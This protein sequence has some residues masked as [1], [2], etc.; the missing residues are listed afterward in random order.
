VEISNHSNHTKY[1][2]FSNSKL[3][4]VSADEI[5][6][7]EPTPQ[8]FQ[9]TLSNGVFYG[10][11]PTPQ[12]MISGAFIIPPKTRWLYN[13]SR[14]NFKENL[15]PNHL[16]IEPEGDVLGSLKKLAKRYL[17]VTPN[18]KIAIENSGGVDSA[19]LIGILNLLGVE[20][21]LIG[22]QSDSYEARTERI[23][24]DH[25]FRELPN[26]ALVVPD[27]FGTAFGGLS[28]VP[29]HAV[30]SASL[31]YFERHTRMAEAAQALGADIVL[32]GVAGDNLFCVG[33]DKQPHYKIPQSLMPWC[34][35]DNWVSDL[36]YAPR[37]MRY[38]AGHSLLSVIKTIVSTRWNQ[39]EDIMKMWA[40]REFAEI[41]PTQLSQFAYKA[42]HDRWLADGI[43]ASRDEICALADRVHKKIR[44]PMLKGSVVKHNL[45]R[46]FEMNHSDMSRFII[47]LSFVV[48]A[49]SRI[50]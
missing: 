24:Q 11:R 3:E 35:A 39:P 19:T 36:I 6:P 13:G 45:D 20:I 31:L 38:V 28:R 49:N 22:L 29:P 30:P 32:N 2:I 17:R 50:P 37:G 44:N 1:A 42:S 7:R 9:N 5:I 46:Y 14:L 15:S 33:L 4:L 43:H 12:K 48:W 18:A 34:L 8:D 25:F 23:I 16:P 41:L 27:S 40:R 21:Y 10:R 26:G 47:S